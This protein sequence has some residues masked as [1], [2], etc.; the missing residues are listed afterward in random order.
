VVL[1]PINIKKKKK[2]KV[3]SG[4]KTKLSSPKKMWVF[5]GRGTSFWSFEI[6]SCCSPDWPPTPNS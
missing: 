6:R 2:K 3:K 1:I 4:R 5:F